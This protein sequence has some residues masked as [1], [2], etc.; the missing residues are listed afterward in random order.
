[1]PR[2]FTL[3]VLFAIGVA[4]SIALGVSFF[5]RD[6]YYLAGACAAALAILCI[7]FIPAWQVHR[8]GVTD[9]KQRL[10]LISEPRK[11][12]IQLFGGVFLLVGVW[13]SAQ[14]LTV[15]RDYNK[16]KIV[17]DQ[18]VRAMQLLK[19]TSLTARLGGIFALERIARD[20]EKDHGNIVEI[21]TA[22]VRSNRPVTNDS[23]VSKIP[24]DI[25]A[26][27]TVLG[28]RKWRISEPRPPDLSNTNLNGIVLLGVNLDS[29]ILSG[30]HLNAAKFKGVYLRGAN[31]RGIRITD[32]DESVYVSDTELADNMLRLRDFNAKQFHRID[33]S[34]DFRRCNLS[35]A[36]LTGSIC[37]KTLMRSLDLS[38]AILRYANF[39][40]TDFVDANLR[41]ADFTEINITLAN[42]AGCDL[43]NAVALD[44][45]EL[46][47]VF[48][49]RGAKIDSSLI[50]SMIKL[51]SNQYI[52]LLQ[53]VPAS[54]SILRDHLKPYVKYEPII[55]V[56]P[57]LDYR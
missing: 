34:A 43:R 36:D 53:R 30:V 33:Y 21:L 57:S 1:M 37:K 44:P 48:S 56:D 17:T 32:I 25:Q 52:K 40:R 46:L 6:D 49:L 8:T 38:N 4:M 35:G 42:M 16:E 51:D 41:G 19:D 11:T 55:I 5:N 26:I 2:I 29:T 7:W 28:R 27:L 20:S 3:A 39:E 47:S 9:E 31:L 18:F 50:T 15:D 10:E 12:V 24:E 14:Q 23:T 22:F 45:R 54:Y 13:I